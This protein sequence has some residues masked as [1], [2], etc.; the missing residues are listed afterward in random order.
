MDA[1]ELVPEK[2]YAKKQINQGMIVG[3][4]AFIYRLADTQTYLSTV[5]CK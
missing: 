5:L 2:K 4:S 3:E 1:M